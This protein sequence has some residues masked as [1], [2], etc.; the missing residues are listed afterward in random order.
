[1][2]RTLELS[3]D[4]NFIN[5]N[6]GLRA[7]PVFGREKCVGSGKEE[8]CGSVGGPWPP[9]EKPGCPRRNSVSRY[10]QH[11]SYSS[12]PVCCPPCLP[13]ARNR[14]PDAEPYLTDTLC[15]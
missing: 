11:H 2:H 4:C 1:M 3:L 5:K 12:L 14:V 10:P 13:L 6:E 9:T 7:F 8:G 15:F